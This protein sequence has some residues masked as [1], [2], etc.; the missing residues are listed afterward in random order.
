MAPNDHTTLS[1]EVRGAS[2]I[3]LQ[4]LYIV[5]KLNRALGLLRPRRGW[6]PETPSKLP[7]VIFKSIQN[8]SGMCALMTSATAVTTWWALR[9]G[10]VRAKAF[11][12]L[13][14]RCNAS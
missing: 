2:E 8:V 6:P 10:A 13:F 11:N 3:I 5:D 4:P 9:H 14:M 1:T 12:P 7:T